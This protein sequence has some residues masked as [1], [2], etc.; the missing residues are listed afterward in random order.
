VAKI[1][2]EKIKQKPS[3][4]NWRKYDDTKTPQN[5]VKGKTGTLM[6]NN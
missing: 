2:L 6:F 5:T 4:P 3:E 1:K